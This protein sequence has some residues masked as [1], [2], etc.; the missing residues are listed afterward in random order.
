MSLSFFAVNFPR[1]P[2]VRVFM[3]LSVSRFVF[4]LG[5]DC[6]TTKHF[7]M[8]FLLAAGIY[9]FLSTTSAD[10]S[11]VYK[12]A[13]ASIDARVADLLS[14]MTI[15]DKT[16]QLMQGD[17]TEWLNTTSGEINT[18]GLAGFASSTASQFYVGHDMLWSRLSG[19]IKAAQDYMLH[20][21]TLGIPALAQTEGIHGLRVGNATIFNSPIGYACSWNPALIEQMEAV[22]ALESSAFGVN[23]LYA[24]LGD[25]A[26][27]LRYG[28]VEETFGEDGFLAGEIGYAY[29]KG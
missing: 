16:S 4:L 15:E 26:R 23:Q 12:N 27:E 7:E 13:T 28:R 5:V 18:S 2:G 21:T 9:L 17:I 25:L 29:I 14:R 6:Q 11:P 3:W 22:I 1:K 20:N 19:G 24:P 10:S 8:R